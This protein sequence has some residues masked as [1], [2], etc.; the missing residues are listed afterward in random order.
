M[1][2]TQVAY[3]NACRRSIISTSQLNIHGQRAANYAAL[4]FLLFPRE[5]A[6][7]ATGAQE[8][9]MKPHAKLFIVID[10]FLSFHF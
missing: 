3:L 8:D 4:L 1:R 10:D 6:V 2:D 7:A 9:R 5:Q